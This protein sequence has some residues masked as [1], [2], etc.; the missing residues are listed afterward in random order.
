MRILK[1]NQFQAA[2]L[3]CECGW[4]GCGRDSVTG[5][6]T[7]QGVNRHCP[8]CGEHFGYVAFPVALES[9][10]DSREPAP[11][12]KGRNIGPQEPGKLH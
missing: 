6:T 7:D 4:N 2:R 5:E 3:V 9:V 10:N 8:E 12:R 11:E 1:W